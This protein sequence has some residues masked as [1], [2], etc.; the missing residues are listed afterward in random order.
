MTVIA[1]TAAL[2]IVF[3]I[4]MW[5]IFLHRFNGIFSTEKIVG[6]TREAINERIREANYAA[7]R[8]M[9]LVDE[10][11]KELNQV[12]AEADR[13]LAVLKRELNTQQ[14]ESEFRAAMAATKASKKS[15]SKKNSV[16]GQTELSF[17]E[18]ARTELGISDSVL[19]QQKEQKETPEILHEIPVVNPV[20]YR[21]EDQIVPKKDFS[22][23][24]KELHGSGLPVEE[25]ARRTSRT[26]QEV[27]LVIQ[28][29]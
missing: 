20:I 13:R 18:K 15:E 21:A 12:K 27:G 16:P 23:I 22:Q 7:E 5:L 19:P 17:T 14:R 3:N 28:M 26:V 29:L 9:N 1:F 24:V 11:I 10:K 4:L 8:N 2:L 25:I 6:E